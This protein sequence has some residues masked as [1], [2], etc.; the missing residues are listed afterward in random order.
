MKLSE[1][2]VEEIMILVFPDDLRNDCCC[3]KIQE[4]EE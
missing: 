3:C 2:R 1:R 4:K